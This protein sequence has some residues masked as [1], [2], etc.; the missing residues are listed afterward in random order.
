MEHYLLNCIYIFDENL[1]RP[2]RS[3]INFSC[4]I[5]AVVMAILFCGTLDYAKSSLIAIS[6]SILNIAL[7]S[8][9]QK[10][11]GSTN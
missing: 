9:L 2:V 7:T 8:I 11:L 6:T 4:I 5:L 3:I 1:S 10:L